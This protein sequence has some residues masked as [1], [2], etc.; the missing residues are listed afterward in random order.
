MFWTMTFIPLVK[1]AFIVLRADD[2]GEGGTFALYSLLCRHAKVGLLPNHEVADDELLTYEMEKLQKPKVESR[3]R[4]A[5]EKNK[6]SHYLMLF[7]ALLGACM[8]IADGILTPAI[9]DV[10]VPTACAILVGLF[11]LQHF[12]T[13]KIGFI[14]APVVVLWLLF[15]GGVGLYN[16]LYWNRQVTRAVSPKY[17]YKFIRNMDIK[18]WRPLSSVL[19]SIA[20][21]EAMFANLGHF[22]KKSVQ[23]AFVFLVYPLLIV[24][25]MGQTAF[26]SKNHLETY[27][28]SSIPG[29]VH[30]AFTVISLL[31]SV[32]GSQATITGTFSIINQCLALDCFPRVKVVHT[33]EKIHGQVYI[34]DVNW[35]LMVLCLTITIC[36]EDK[37]IGN[38]TGLAIVTGMLM[39]TCLMS[40]I[41]ALYWEKNMLISACFLIFFGSIEA[42]YLSAC[43][44][45]FQKGAWILVILTVVLL[46]V[47]FAWHYGTMKKYNFDTNNRVSM[48]W[49]T[50]LGPALGV[51]RVPGIGIIYTDI[52]RGIPAFFSHFV[53]NL[54][55]FHQ[56]LVFVSFKSVPVP[57]VPPSRQYLIGRFGPKEYG[58]YRC[59]VRYGYRSGIRET[60]DFEDNLIRRIGE[61]ISVED[62]GTEALTS[63]EGRMIVIGNLEQG[64]NAL[65]P[66]DR[67]S[68]VSLELVNIEHSPIQ[69]SEQS[70]VFHPL[71]VRRK[72]VRFLLPPESPEMSSVR[73]ELQE[74]VDAR[75]SG[76]AYFLGHAHL[77][78]HRG[79]NFLKKLTIMLY[80]FLDKNCRAPLLALNI[81]H[82]ALV[83][84][85]MVYSI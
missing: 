1:Y 37:S 56:V 28:S 31:A 54:P 10:P 53:T 60:A 41:I 76:T 67:D 59:I 15:I 83:E 8:V 52:V 72:R 62:S 24:S 69:T 18:S 46:T 81:P 64:G 12:G 80:V 78:A 13:H 33:S 48:E 43:V 63:T 47:M 79:S 85:G 20:G 26:I 77:S 3:A 17:M 27:L 25:Y 65:I 74:L 71:L 55:A 51:V 14:F 73:E 22:S 70:Q 11:T 49:L 57:Y 30:H 4:R 38:A 35:I 19:L 68:D 32:V 58:V 36:F 75:D 16:I 44:S 45:N 40:L 82:A 23:V 34:P 39:T 42:I 21:S 6:S 2:K 29:S 9:S 84:V 50:D 5:I 7:L 66:Q 61:F